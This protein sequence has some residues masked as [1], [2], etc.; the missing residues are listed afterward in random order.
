MASL[1]NL[2]NTDLVQFG[3]AS[4]SNCKSSIPGNLLRLASII[5]PKCQQ[6]QSGQPALGGCTRKHHSCY[7]EQNEKSGIP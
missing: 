6:W 3:E 7:F 4:I 1:P 5:W 2:L